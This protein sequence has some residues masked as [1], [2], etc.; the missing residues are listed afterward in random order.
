MDVVRI[1]SYLLSGL[2]TLVVDDERTYFQ[3]EIRAQRWTL[4]F[5]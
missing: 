4:F 1:Q 5:A 3:S 2:P